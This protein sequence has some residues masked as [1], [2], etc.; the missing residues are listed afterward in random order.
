MNKKVR[1]GLIGVGGIAQGAHLPPLTQSPDV[2]IAALCDV[3]PDTLRKVGDRYNVPESRRFSDYRDLVACPEVDAVEVCTPN[4]MHIPCALAAVQA[5]KPVNVEKPLALSCQ[6]AQPLLNLLKEKPV[7]SM[8]CFSYRFRPAVQYAKHLLEQ[9]LLGDLVSVRVEYLK[10]SAFWEGR[11]LDW[12]FDKTIAG[13][14]V[15][16]DLGAHLVDMTRYLLGEFRAVSADCGTIVKERKR[17]DSEEYAPVTTD[18][19]CHFIA[20]LGK[21]SEIFAN[22]SISRCCIGHA[23]TIRYDVYG[24]KG[25][26]SFDLNNPD[27]LGV[28]V[29]EVDREC[30]SLHTV[31]VPQKYACQQEQTFVDAVLGRPCDVLPDLNDGME[32]QKILDA[33]LL[34][35]EEKRWVSLD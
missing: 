1:I 28:C 25:V 26:L 12:R 17:L 14:G 21:N 8:M 10:D 5:G 32:C 6:D 33:L 24:S 2:E 30:K 23:N 7:V 13:T 29:G 35:S 19:Y 31:K 22:F 18:D 9:G 4:N 16:G 11:R 34:S 27:V 20:R 15:L 3:N